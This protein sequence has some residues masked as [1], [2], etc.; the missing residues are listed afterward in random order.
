MSALAPVSDTTEFNVECLSC[1]NVHQPRPKSSLWWQAKKRWEQGFIDALRINGE[2]CGCI[3]KPY[4]PNAPFRVFGY[5][6]MCE[7][8][9]IPCMTFVE[10]VQLY[11]RHTFDV[12]FITGVSDRVSDKLRY[13]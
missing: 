4:L 12:V 1:C 3:E 8:F 5:D 11:R 6:G 7:D 9:N 10:A 13:M 2:E